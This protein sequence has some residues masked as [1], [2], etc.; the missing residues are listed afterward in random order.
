MVYFNK[1]ITDRFITNWNQR[2][3]ASHVPLPKYTI[4]H[5]LEIKCTFGWILIVN[6]D[7]FSKNMRLENGPFGRRDCILFIIFFVVPWCK[8]CTSIWWWFTG[9]LRP[10]C[11][12]CPVWCDECWVAWWVKLRRRLQEM[13]GMSFLRWRFLKNNPTRGAFKSDGFF[14][15]CFFWVIRGTYNKPWTL[16]VIL[17]V[18]YKA[19]EVIR[20]VPQHR[21][22]FVLG[23]WKVKVVPCQ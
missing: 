17:F 21:L 20:F 15:T 7:M 2:S 18:Q 6:Q 10:P 23:P 1:S 19:P 11:V 3:P 5:R 14:R 4:V 13:R 22:M 12:P 9:F 16:C 8:D